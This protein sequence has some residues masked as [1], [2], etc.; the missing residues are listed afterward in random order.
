MSTYEH[1]L[2]RIDLGRYAHQWTKPSI[3]S[4]DD[5]NSQSSTISGTLWYV[6]LNRHAKMPSSTANAAV[7]VVSR[8]NTTMG[9]KQISSPSELSIY[10]RLQV[11]RSMFFEALDATFDM[12]TKQENP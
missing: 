9:T 8:T 4:L 11:P 12:S 1:I 3:R 7:R 10:V 5:A 2:N 6:Q